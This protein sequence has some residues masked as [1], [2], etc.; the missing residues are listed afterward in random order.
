MKKRILPLVLALALA[1]GLM[2]IPAQAAGV[3]GLSVLS[4]NSTFGVTVKDFASTHSVEAFQPVIEVETDT[5]LQALSVYHYNSGA[6]ATPGVISLYD[7]ATRAKIGSWNATGRDGNTWWDADVN[8]QLEAGKSYFVDCSDRLTW[9]IEEGEDGKQYFVYAAYGYAGTLPAETPAPV[10]ETPAPVVETPAPVVETPEPVVET[11]A[12]VVE[13]AAPVTADQLSGFTLLYSNVAGASGKDFKSAPGTEAF[14]PLFS[15]SGTNVVLQAI[16]LNH[17]NGG[18]GSAPGIISLY[19]NATRRLV[20]SWQAVGRDGNTWWDAYP[21]IELETG[22]TYFIDC[23]D[24]QTWRFGG[25]DKNFFN[26][27]A[28]GYHVPSGVAP[29][30]I[31][32][33]TFP[34]AN[35]VVDGVKVEWPEHLPYI[36][37]DSRTMTVLVPIADAL[38]LTSAWDGVAGVASYTDGSRTLYFPVGSNCAYADNGEVIH[39]D[40]QADIRDG[41][42]FT[43]IRCLA[44]YFGYDVSWYGGTMTVYINSPA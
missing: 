12:P 29:V 43:P 25:E 3:T 10:V 24:R 11:P 39:M 13:T 42:A 30:D 21:N 41:A 5:V 16:S 19:D 23:S 27:M 32:C 2:A 17:Y 44:E 20:G 38:G 31:A 35:V 14:Q 18:A 33:Y 22:K 4:T 15:V 37:V 7:N 9:S 36:N 6:G 40:T 8:V 28:Y 34:S 26:F 1:F